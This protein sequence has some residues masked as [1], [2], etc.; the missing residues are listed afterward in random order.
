MA[1]NTNNCCTH[2]YTP[3]EELQSVTEESLLLVCTKQN[4]TQ[5]YLVFIQ[6]AQE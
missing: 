6:H 3:L 5:Y 1:H 4:T 2:K